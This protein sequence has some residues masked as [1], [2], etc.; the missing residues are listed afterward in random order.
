MS[1]ME[2]IRTTKS[3]AKVFSSGLLEASTKATSKVIS[4]MGLES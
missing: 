1:M 4:G 3:K 2:T